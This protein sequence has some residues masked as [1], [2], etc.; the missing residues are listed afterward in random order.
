MQIAMQSTEICDE[1]FEKITKFEDSLCNLT[2][3][4]NINGIMKGSSFSNDH[5]SFKDVFDKSKK[6]LFSD[7]VPSSWLGSSMEE[8]LKP[9]CQ[10]DSSANSDTNL[11]PHPPPPPPPYLLTLQGNEDVLVHTL[12]KSET[13]LGSDVVDFKLIAS[14]ILRHHSVIK[15]EL[16]E[17]P[18]DGIEDN[19][20]KYWCVTIAPLQR[21]AEV[22]VN[23][24][25]IDG[26][27]TLKHDDLVSVG[28][29]HLFIYK[30]PFSQSCI[31]PVKL[32]VKPNHAI[33]MTPS[34]D[35]DIFYDINKSKALPTVPR[36][37]N[38]IKAPFSYSLEEESHVFQLIFDAFEV[39]STFPTDHVLTP[40]TL[41]CHCVFHSC[42]NFPPPEVYCSFEKL[43]KGLT[44]IVEVSDLLKFR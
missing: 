24:K 29:H 9:E 23:G 38:N 27:Q 21:K 35:S 17:K 3:N 44:R 15:R 4:C 16:K 39:W 31:T 40:A 26:P 32:S 1:D 33:S 13:L 12:K 11:N 8:R 36:K 5:T 20:R 7:L 14:D 19:S 6:S 25:K 41:L 37:N 30:D 42:L 34:N 18:A 2:N 28:K 10:L 43:I 22:R